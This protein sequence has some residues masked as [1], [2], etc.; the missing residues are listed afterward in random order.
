MGSAPFSVLDL[1]KVLAGTSTGVQADIDEAE[2]GMRGGATR[3]DVEKMFQLIYLTFTAPRADPA[4]FEALKARLR[5][6]LAN[7]AGAAGNGVSRRARLRA[8][9]GPSQGD[10]R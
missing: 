1:N 8:D 6:M 3:K 7:Q 5:P 10:V 2:E 9:A 4:E